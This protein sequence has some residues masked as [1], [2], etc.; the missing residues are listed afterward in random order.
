M[1]T[2]N[3]EEIKE[4]IIELGEDGNY[5]EQ[6][7]YFLQSLGIEFN[8]KIAQD[9][10]KAN[11]AT[12]ENTCYRVELRKNKDAE[13]SLRDYTFVVFFNQSIIASKK[14]ITPSEYDLLA[15]LQKYDIGTIEEFCNEFDYNLETDSIKEMNYIQD[16]YKAV[17]EEFDDLRY[18]FT[19]EEIE[20]LQEIN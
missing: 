14:N 17:K 19:H 10:Y 1:K 2:L 5:E 7:N 11:W 9:C 6:G 3:Y 12:P 15:C 13:N 8:F 20:I 4:R 18:F 16:T